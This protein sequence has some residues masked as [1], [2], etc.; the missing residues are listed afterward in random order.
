[1]E[2]IFYPTPT[3]KVVLQVLNS[4]DAVLIGLTIFMAMYNCIMF[5][6]KKKIRRFFIILFYI[7][8]FFCL[9]SWEITAI[10]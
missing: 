1:M 9:L 4:I 5:V 8:V 2:D 6:W 3:E 7:L 10:A